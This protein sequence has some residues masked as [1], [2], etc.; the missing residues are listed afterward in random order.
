MIPIEIRP[1]ER[2]LIVAPHPDDECIGAGG[3]LARYGAQCDVLLLTNGCAY[4]P[5]QTRERSIAIRRKEFDR[6]MALAGVHAYRALGIDDETLMSHQDCME[7]F[8]L[9]PY[10][11]IFVTNHADNHPD[12]QAAAAC[13][14]S[15]L[16][17][18][19]WMVPVY[20][21]EIA[22]PLADP[23]AYLDISDA[24]ERK[25]AF[26]RCHASQLANLDYAKLAASI[27]AYRAVHVPRASFVEAYARVDAGA[28]GMADDLARVAAQ[29]QRYQHLYHIACR[30]LD[31]FAHGQS[32]ANVLVA[33]GCHTVALYGDTPFARILF[34]AL[35]GTDVRVS[36]L[37]DRKGASHHL[38]DVPVRRPAD[39]LPPVDLVIITVSHD[40]D[41]IGRQLE[42]QGLSSVSIEH[43]LE[44]TA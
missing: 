32:I 11:K 9:A 16:A 8:D 26:I 27:N 30:W 5:Q 36:C 25:R 18:Q 12:H 44:G 34:D 15:A 19:G 7:A 1:E 2:L 22:T 17:A 43:L 39:E 6:E 24:I 20:E 41:A 14:R 3:V 29:K 42:A 35:D 21:Y 37:I 4:D 40:A 13:V 23:A 10:A 28:D 33:R 38:P 31:G